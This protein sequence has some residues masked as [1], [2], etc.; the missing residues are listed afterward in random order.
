MKKGL[1]VIDDFTRWRHNVEGDIEYH[2]IESEA[3]CISGNTRKLAS[4]SLNFARM[5]PPN[6]SQA[7]FM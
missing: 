7:I 3:S 2:S 1:G 5:N 4:K 6:A